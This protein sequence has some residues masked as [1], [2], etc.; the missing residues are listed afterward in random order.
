[1]DTQVSNSRPE[2]SVLTNHQELVC[3]VEELLRADDHLRDVLLAY[4]EANDKLAKFVE[5]GEPEVAS[6]MSL[7]A[8]I[9][10]QEVSQGIADFEMARRQVRL[11]LIAV[12][13]EQG[14]TQSEVGRMLGVSRQL[15]SRLALEADPREWRV[16][17]SKRPLS[18]SRQ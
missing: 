18:A 17:L 1:M 14:T 6:L 11:A 5:Q 2:D 10:H 12:A 15:V 3:R 13:K 8:P 16:A 4:R 7:T 9:R